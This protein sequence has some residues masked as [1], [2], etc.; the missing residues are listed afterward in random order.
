M[1]ARAFATRVTVIIIVIIHVILFRLF[2]YGRRTIYSY[3]RAI[4]PCGF[5]SLGNPFTACIFF[6][7]EKKSHFRRYIHKSVRAEK[8]TVLN[9]N[10]NGPDDVIAFSEPGLKAGP[11]GSTVLE[12][13]ESRVSDF[14]TACL[15]LNHRNTYHVTLRLV[16]AG[17]KKRLKIV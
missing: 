6:D 17:K 15:S 10:P 4:T 1:R 9:K 14:Y 7:G 11:S 13:R 3:S 8:F 5:N 12:L 2:Y 16:M